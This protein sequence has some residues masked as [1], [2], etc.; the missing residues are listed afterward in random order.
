MLNAIM[1]QVNVSSGSITLDNNPITKGTRRQMSYVLQSDIF[2]ASL[3]LRETL[4]VR[5]LWIYIHQ[6]DW[7]VFNLALALRVSTMPADALAPKVTSASAG[8]LLVL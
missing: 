1:G 4:R 7:H 3:T 6:F 2:L 8:M 5:S